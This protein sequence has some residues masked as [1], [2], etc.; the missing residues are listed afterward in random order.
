MTKIP[1]K[2]SRDAGFAQ[3]IENSDGSGA[4]A[5]RLDASLNDLKQGLQR[6]PSSEEKLYLLKQRSPRDENDLKATR[7]G[8]HAPGGAMGAQASLADNLLRHLNAGSHDALN[9]ISSVFE[10]HHYDKTLL[11]AYIADKSAANLKALQV[12]IR[13]LAVS[14]PTIAPGC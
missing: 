6:R 10:F 11:D 14:G 12:Q 5:I 4:N 3:P 13:N 8:S 7:A 1:S 9:L 2:T